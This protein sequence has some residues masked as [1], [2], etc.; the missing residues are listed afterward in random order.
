MEEDIK[1]SDLLNLCPN[2]SCQHKNSNEALFCSKCGE[3]LEYTGEIKS[4]QEWLTLASQGDTNAHYILANIYIIE[5]RPYE[6]FHYIQKP[7]KE[8]MPFAQWKLAWMYQYARG[9]TENFEKAVEWYTKASNQDYR[10]AYYSLALTYGL[11]LGVKPSLEKAIELYQK[12]SEQG[13]PIATRS[14]GSHYL[15]GDGVEKDEKKGLTLLFKAVE[16][17][18]PT[19]ICMVGEFYFYG[20]F[21]LEKNENKAFELLERAVNERDEEATR[22]YYYLKSQS[23]NKS[24][25][26]F[27]A[28]AVY[29]S[30]TAPKVIILREFRDQKLLTNKYGEAFV[31]FYYKYSPPVADYIAKRKV[32]SEVVRVAFIEPLVWIVQCFTKRKVI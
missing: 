12:A 13:H 24:S 25:G 1:M 27:I 16:Q 22:L 28:T 23:S 31:Q 9:T 21:G 29:N 7:A 15:Y 17:Q 19:A 6:A 30:P 10:E 5:K 11:G 8:G 32:L 18:E 26:C 2:K 4:E 14:L 3:K 20:K